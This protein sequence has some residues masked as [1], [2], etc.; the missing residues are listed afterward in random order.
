MDAN[1]MYSFFLIEVYLIYNVVP[2][3]AVQQSDSVIHIKTF[4]FY[5]LFH[6]SLSHIL[7]IVPCAM[8]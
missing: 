5:I 8:H 4:F 1:L 3:S 6:C 2:I 7:N